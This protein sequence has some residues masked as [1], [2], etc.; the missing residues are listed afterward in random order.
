MI[1]F[2]EKLSKRKDKQDRISELMEEKETIDKNIEEDKREYSDFQ[3]SEKYLKVLNTLER[4]KDKKNEIAMFEKKMMN[5]V[6]NLSRPITKFSYMAPKATQAR[7]AIMQ[8]EPL[9]ILSDSFESLHIFNE[10][11]KHVVENSIQIKD[12]DK[13]IHQIDEI[14]NSLPSLSSNLKNLKEGLTQL[15]SSVNSTNMKHM[16]DMKA[17]TEMYEKYRSENISKIEETKNII[18]ELDSAIEVLKKKIEE[19]VSDITNRNY[20]ILQYQD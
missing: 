12:P 14:V 15:E 5:M 2:K 13:T 17:K 6:S 16:E 7:L 20:S 11:K 18:N 4:I 19:N 9:E 8:N 10:L 3:K 1:L